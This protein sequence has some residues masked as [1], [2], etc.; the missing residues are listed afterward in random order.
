MSLR[1]AIATALFDMADQA[2]RQSKRK[3][4]FVDDGHKAKRQHV[5]DTQRSRRKHSGADG[6]HDEK[7]QCVSSTFEEQSTRASRLASRLTRIEAEM[8]Y[9]R[10]HMSQEEFMRLHPLEIGDEIDADYV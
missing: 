6:R 2:G 1:L 4:S 10:T 9:V 8:N 7:K 3:H 5:L